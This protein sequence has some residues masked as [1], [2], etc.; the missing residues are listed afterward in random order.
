MDNGE[1]EL[2]LEWWQVALGAGVTVLALGYLG[3]LGKSAIDEAEQET[4]GQ[5]P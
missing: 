4:E 5:C 3:K 2:P 1:G